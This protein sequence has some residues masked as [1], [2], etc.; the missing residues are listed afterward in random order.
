MRQSPEWLLV[1]FSGLFGSVLA[2]L[3]E[4]R[5]ERRSASVR[6]LS[7]AA[8]PDASSVPVMAHETIAGVIARERKKLQELGWDIATPRKTRAGYVLVPLEKEH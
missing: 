8:Y 3:I 2:M 6:E 7:K 4:C 1:H 5:R